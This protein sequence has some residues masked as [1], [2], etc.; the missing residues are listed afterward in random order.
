MFSYMFNTH[1]GSVFFKNVNMTC[2]TSD[3]THRLNI[4]HHDFLS[5]VSVVNK[6]NKPTA[7]AVHIKIN[8][9]GYKNTEIY[10]TQGFRAKQGQCIAKLLST[11]AA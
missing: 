9:T 6:K 3:S 4:M 8:N 7:F 2:F 5:I 1:M 10:V 11:A